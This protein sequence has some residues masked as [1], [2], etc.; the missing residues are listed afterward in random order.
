MTDE[1]E[2]I[3]EDIS[4]GIE[5]L[6]AVPVDFFLPGFVRSFLLQGKHKLRRKCSDRVNNNMLCT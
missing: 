5:V 4:D 1:E 3:L 6:K 2:D